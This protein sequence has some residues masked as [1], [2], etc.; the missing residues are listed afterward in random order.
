LLPAGL[1]KAIQAQT[2]L[3]FEISNVAYLETC[4]NLLKN[5]ERFPTATCQTITLSEITQ[6]SRLAPPGAVQTSFAATKLE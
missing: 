1:E 5:N 6:A 4:G 3:T 2:I